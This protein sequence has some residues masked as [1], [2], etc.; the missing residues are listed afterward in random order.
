MELS[1]GKIYEAY[2]KNDLDKFSA[3]ELLFSLIDNSESDKV[4]IESIEEIEKIE[5]YDNNAFKILEN[6]LISDSSEGVRNAA[7]LALKNLFLD[8]ALEPMAFA[9]SHEESPSC[10]KTIYETLIV[11]IKNIAVNSDIITKLI[12]LT[13][14][15]KIK[16]VEFKADFDIICEKKSLE[17][18]T[19]LELA[20]ILINFF[21]L[22]FLEK[23]YWRLKFK[24]EKCKI[25]ELD[26]IF[27][28]LMSLP[29]ALKNL[30]SVKT[31]VLR[32]NQI[33]DIP[34]WIGDLSSLENLNLN[35]NN[36]RNLPS[37]IGSLISLKSL[38]LWKNELNDLPLSIGTLKSLK[39]LNLRINSIKK[40][41]DTI[42]Q[43]ISLKDLNLHD[44]KLRDL[45]ASIGNLT[46]LKKL[47]VSW[48]DLVAIPN[49]IGSLTSL[50]TLDLERNELTI[51]P[52][53][54]GALK[55]LEI[56]NISDNKLVSIPE[57]I[58]SLPSLQIL[59]VS[60]NNLK[61]LPDSLVSLQLK[62][63]YIGDNKFNNISNLLSKL[64]NNGIQ[65]YY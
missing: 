45:P 41:P 42:G 44:N 7:A 48:N 55:S 24:L 27:K 17:N 49:T 47:N 62:E 65:I 52:D 10:L 3:A 58:G 59:N 20:E 18:F 40:L 9:L 15:K 6:L 64:E 34:E 61:T 1:P 21:T 30:S 28:G 5:I 22:L 43:L 46:S 11:V 29:E 26:F 16:N 54:I 25:I 57:S 14:I 31:L 19:N 51:I 36:I 35:V 37:T 2:L 63:F 8:K 12:L 39:Y 13:E 53:S 50:Q 4:R 38:S 60:K 56:L 23:I 32:Y 33:F